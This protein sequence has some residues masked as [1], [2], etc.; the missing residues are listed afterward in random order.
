MRVEVVYAASADE[1]SVVA[2]ELAAGATVE[3]A[4]RASGLL[5]RYPEI[6]LTQNAVGIFGERVT[7]DRVVEDSE[8][9]EIY[10]PLVADPREARRRRATEKGK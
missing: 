6:D 2:V 7:L 3:N 1:Q 9:V 4:I 8:R 10:R 5:L